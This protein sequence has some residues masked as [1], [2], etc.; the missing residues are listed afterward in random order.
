VQ[1]PAAWN[2]APQIV[3]DTCRK[4]VQCAA[5]QGV[6]LPE[7][8]IKAVVASTPHISSHLASFLS[9]AVYR[10]RT[11]CVRSGVQ[12]LVFHMGTGG[13]SL[14]EAKQRNLFNS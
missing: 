2:P 8:A 1:G 11:R 14:G 3:K 7:L 9:L 13:F 6:E 12:L 5:E 4:A 10:S